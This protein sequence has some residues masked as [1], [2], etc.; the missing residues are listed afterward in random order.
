MLLKP[1]FRWVVRIKSSIHMNARAQCFTR[2]KMYSL[3]LLV[4]LMLWLTSAYI[5]IYLFLK[6]TKNAT[7][8]TKTLVSGNLSEKENKNQTSKEKVNFLP[9][10]DVQPMLAGFFCCFFNHK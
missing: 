7:L 6:H 10:Q 3:H 2:K 9:L 4:V 1:D 8:T 5:Y